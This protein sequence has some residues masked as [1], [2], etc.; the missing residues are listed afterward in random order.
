VFVFE[1]DDGI[2]AAD[3]GA[4]QAVGVQRRGRAD[5]P[6]PGTDVKITAPVWE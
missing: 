2:V 3:G 5:D 6:Q 1:E 4:Q